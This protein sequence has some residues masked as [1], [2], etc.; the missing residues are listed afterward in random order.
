MLKSIRKS[1]CLYR[2]KDAL[3][4]AWR[5]GMRK[6][7][8]HLFP[9]D[10]PPVSNPKTA[11]V[12]AE[13]D[14]FGG[15]YKN[16]LRIVRTLVGSGYSVDVF[17]TGPDYPELTSIAEETGKVR[18]NVSFIPQKKRRGR[19]KILRYVSEARF[20]AKW[21]GAQRLDA[22]VMVFSITSPG[23]FLWRYPKKM[24]QIFIFR[25]NPEGPLHRLAGPWFRFLAG[26]DVQL[27]GVSQAT[28]RKLARSWGFRKSDPRL[29]CLRNPGAAEGQPLA[30]FTGSTKQVLMV[31]RLP[32]NK[33]PFFW[34]DVAKAVSEKTRQKVRFVWL[35]DGELRD[36][37][38]S[39]AD[40]SGI[41]GLVSFP[42]FTKDPYPVYR[43]SFLYLHLAKVE[44]LGN[45]V[46][47]ALAMGIPSIVSDIGGL[48][49][50]VQDGVNGRVVRIDNVSH[51]VDAVVDIIEDEDKHADMAVAAG[52][53]FEERFSGSAW[54]AQ[55]LRVIG[56]SLPS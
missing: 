31:G 39:Y 12:V 6:E 51:A 18:I 2:L 48:P 32:E 41:S 27:L 46:I 44:P 10:G 36:E 33:N 45:A 54:E 34:L 4:K 13:F 26:H 8:H 15:P 20:L 11:F 14:P 5:D 42:G 17:P 50:I 25:S 43:Q 3:H 1:L 28:T 35:G 40:M 21:L 29:G 19:F 56:H 24:R 30:T 52:R 47:D 16:L 53:I 22:G 38:I 49:E 9:P 7:G 37:A 23:R 55:F